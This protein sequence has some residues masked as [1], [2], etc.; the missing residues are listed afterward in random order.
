MRRIDL[1]ERSW[2]DERGWGLRPLEAAGVPPE[3]LGDVHVV[4]LTPGAVRGNHAHP[5]GTE[6]ILLC[7]G[8]VEVAWRGGEG[9]APSETRQVGGDHPVLYEIPPGTAHAFRN[10]SQG[11]VHLVVWNDEVDPP[12]VPAEP[13]LL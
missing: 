5:R 11:V 13:P 12:T 1:S 9:S 6:W 8:P 4:S 2:S 7:G 10:A 3:R